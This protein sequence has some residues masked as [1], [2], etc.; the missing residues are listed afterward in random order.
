MLLLL[1]FGMLGVTDVLFMSAAKEPKTETQRPKNGGQTREKEVIYRR[2]HHSLYS[3]FRHG[4]HFELSDK[5]VTK[6]IYNCCNLVLC[7]L[8]H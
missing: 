3:M 8:S 5:S 1:Y 2:L 7:M 6:N 4:R